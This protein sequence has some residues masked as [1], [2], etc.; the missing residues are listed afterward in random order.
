M[1]IVEKKLLRFDIQKIPE[2]ESSKIAELPEEYFTL[3]DDVR[4]LEAEVQISFFRTDHFVKV[5]FNLL[6]I[7]ELIC[8]RSLDP[9]EKNVKGSFDILFQPDEVQESET[10]QSAVKQIPP[11]DLVLDI[12]DEVRD[13]I[14]L[15]IPIKKIH[16]RYFD[17][18]GN[19]EEFGTARFGAPAE[20]DEDPIDPRWE[21][22]KKLK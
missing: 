1:A 14:M 5:S 8:D 4:L 20:K 12:E 3:D 11:I 10:E 18:S 7:V 6:S 21:K 9:F 19:P 13:T 22:L 17:E 2:G 15:N 16:P